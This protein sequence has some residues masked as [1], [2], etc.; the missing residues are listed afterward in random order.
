MTPVRGPLNGGGVLS[1]RCSLH[2]LFRL[3]AVRAPAYLANGVSAHFLPRS[4]RRLGFGSCRA[5]CTAC[6]L[7]GEPD[8]CRASGR[9]LKLRREVRA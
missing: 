1:G 4:R 6:G 3:G 5:A 9:F 7:A 2:D 8:V